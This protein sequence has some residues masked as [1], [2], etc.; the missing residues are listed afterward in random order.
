MVD[1]M[2]WTPVGE[3]LPKDDEVVFV[4]IRNKVGKDSYEYGVYSAIYNDE[5]FESV[6]PPHGEIIAWMPYPNPYI[7]EVK[8][9]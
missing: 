6:L 1:V 2:K 8:E 3:G 9:M 4:T 5:L 7:P